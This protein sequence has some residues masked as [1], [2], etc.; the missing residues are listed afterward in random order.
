VLDQG[1]L[2]EEGTHQSLVAK[3][4]L[5]HRLAGLQFAM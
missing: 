3:G 4:G 1:R 5:Y 2:V